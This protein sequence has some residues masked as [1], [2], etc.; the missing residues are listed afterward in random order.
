MLRISQMHIGSRISPS[1]FDSAKRFVIPF[2]TN[3]SITHTLNTFFWYTISAWWFSEVYIWSVE[4]AN[5]GWVNIINKR[6]YELNERP[7]YLR[8]TLIM[9]AF[10]QAFRHLYH[11]YDGLLIPISRS[12]SAS[13]DHLTHPIDPIADQIKS[14][15]KVRDVV[16]L[17]AGK[18]A[19]LTAI[20]LPFIYPFV[21]R[22]IFWSFHLMFAKIM[23]R[24]SRSSEHPSTYPPANPYMIFRTAVVGFLLLSSWEIASLLFTA[25]LVQEPLKK[26]QPISTTTRDPNGTLLSGLKAKK[27][28]VKTFAFWE[29]MII[30]KRFPDRRKAIFS[31]ID[32]AGAPTWSQ[33]LEAGLDVIR[34]IQYRIDPSS[35]PNITQNPSTWEKEREENLPLPRITP[36][37]ATSP[38]VLATPTKKTVYQDILDAAVRKGLGSSQPWT[39]ERTAKVKTAVVSAIE[40]SHI[41]PKEQIGAVMSLLL[42]SPLGWIFRPRP[43]RFIQSLVLGSPNASTSVIIDAVESIKRMSVASL[44]EDTYGKVQ[45]TIPEVIRTFTYAIQAIEGF[46]SIIAGEEG[47]K[48]FL[49][50]DPSRLQEL[51]AV[52][53][54]LRGALRELLDAF[55]QFLQHAGLD[56]EEI[57]IA[58]VWAADVS[59]TKAGRNDWRNRAEKVREKQE[60]RQQQVEAAPNGGEKAGDMVEMAQVSGALQ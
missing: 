11:D 27:E 33:M 29:L 43:L 28:V 17:G 21:F 20:A 49:D 58:R 52:D 1:P 50:D 60:K 54:A 6:D 22:S 14:G 45:G 37:R 53:E 40:R 26:G 15:P 31:D 3:A 42:S 35:V 48:A 32:R 25:F 10:V 5:L 18:V 59:T 23:Y 55:S 19:F 4:G 13:G 41:R 7:I 47:E 8:A 39:P 30:S 2:I 44:S 51:L 56:E 57:G 34:S 12:Q 16:L 24:I 36:K 9:V 38:N 46:I